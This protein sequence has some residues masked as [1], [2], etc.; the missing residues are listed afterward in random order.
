MRIVV[1]DGYTLNPGDLDWSALRALAPCTIHDRTADGDIASRVSHASIVLANKVHLTR[2]T[3][4]GA[5]DLKYIGVTATGYN[6][7]D[8]KAAA[9]R[10]ITVTNVPAYSTMSVAQ[11]VFAHAVGE[12]A[13][14]LYDDAIFMY[15]NHNAGATNVVIAMNNGVRHGLSPG[16]GDDL[17]GEVIDARL[18]AS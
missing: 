12:A 2:E 5:K 16:I 9:E 6:N 3:I 13:G 14:V 17:A 1:L 10:G 7:L 15:F 8:T 11:L 4:L 18:V